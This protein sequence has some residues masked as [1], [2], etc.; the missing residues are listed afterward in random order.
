[1]TKTTLRGNYSCVT[2]IT[3]NN[4]LELDH[5]NNEIK[6]FGHEMLLF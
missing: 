5:G 4:L 2:Q 6:I 3:M 1:M